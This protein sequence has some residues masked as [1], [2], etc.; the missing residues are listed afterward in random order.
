MRKIN[1]SRNGTAKH[2]M[3]IAERAARKS[4]RISLSKSKI[5]SITTLAGL[6]QRVE[7]L[8]KVIGLK[9]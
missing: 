1:N 6:N 8:E 4:A 2:K 9:Y 3:D 7:L 5:T